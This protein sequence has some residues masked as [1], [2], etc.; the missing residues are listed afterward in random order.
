MHILLIGGGWSSEKEV[1]LQGTK[2]IH[3]ALIQLGHQVEFMDP[4]FEFQNLITKATKCDFA[5]INLHGSPGED[6]LIQAILDC[7]NIPYQGSNP[8]SSFLALHKASAKEFFKYANIPTPNWEFLPLARKQ[9][10]ETKLRFPIY[11]KSNRGGSSVDIFLCEHKNDIDQAIQLLFSKGE[12]ILIE[13]QIVGQE[14]TCAILGTEPLPPI[15]IKPQRS[16]SFFDYYCKYTPHAA[17]EICPAPISLRLTEQIQSIALQVHTLLG[18]NGYSRT[19]FM[20]KDNLPFVLEVNT[21]PGMTENSLLP[22]AAQAS[23]YTFEDLLSKLIEM[24]IN[25]SKRNYSS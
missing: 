10:W 13:E 12:E 14:I 6:G 2:A 4:A 22:K 21:L 25:R 11:V 20:V 7:I 17:E 19:D 16:S 9:N 8:A 5:F 23:G 18:L 3:K 1:S 15:L 24:G